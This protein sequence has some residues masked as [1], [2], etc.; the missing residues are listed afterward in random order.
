M[1]NGF[2][3]D[4]LCVF[5]PV[6]DFAIE[7]KKH[8]VQLD[9]QGNWNLSNLSKHLKRHVTNKNHTDESSQDNFPNG[10]CPESAPQN[11]S[12]TQNDLPKRNSPTKLNLLNESQI[13]SMPIYCGENEHDKSNS[14]S[15]K[16]HPSN[17][18]QL[19]YQTFTAQNL[20]LIR[21]TM[22]NSET[23]RFVPVIIDGRTVNLNTLGIAKDGNCMFGSLAHQLFYVKTNSKEHN[24]LTANLRKDVV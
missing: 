10:L 9:K 6:N 14:S 23:K 8:A 15:I 1:E 17:T 22:T 2:R 20:K 13:M 3:A 18:M 5:C 4:V 7:T 11:S 24:D 21:A 16:Q 12:E 19:L